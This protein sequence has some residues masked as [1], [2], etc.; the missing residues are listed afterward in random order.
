MGKPARGHNI[1]SC[2]Q[3]CM[4][5]EEA[6][7]AAEYGILLALVAGA[8]LV[9]VTLMGQKLSSFFTNA[10]NPINP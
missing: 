4:A 9:A 6:A 1:L 2:L 10:L 8:I 5:D 3:R 7:T